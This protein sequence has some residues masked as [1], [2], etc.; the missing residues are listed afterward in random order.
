MTPATAVTNP[1]ELPEINDTIGNYLIRRD[2]VQ[3]IRVCKSWYTSFLPFVWSTIAINNKRSY[4]TVEAFSRHSSLIRHISY[5]TDLWRAYKSSYCSN[6]I[7]LSAYH[8]SPTDKSPIIIGQYHQLRRLLIHGA[9]PKTFF[10]PER[11]VNWKPAH[12]LNNLSNLELSMVRIDPEDT[13]AFWGMCTRLE[14]LAIKFIYIEKLPER[15]MTFERL[16]SLHLS[17][18]SSIQIEPQLDWFTQCPNLTSLSWSPSERQ[19]TRKLDLLSAKLEEGALPKLC[20]LQLEWPKLQDQRL[21]RV[22]NGMKKIKSFTS[23]DEGFD[24]LS[25]QALR[26]HFNHLSA[27]ILKPGLRSNSWMVIAFLTH[28]PT[29]EVLSVGQLKSNDIILSEPWVCKDSLKVFS[30]G[31]IISTERDRERD[32]HQRGVFRRL[33]ELKNLEQLKLV[34]VMHLDITL[35]DVRCG[36]G[37]EMLKTLKRLMRFV[38]GDTIHR[39]RYVTTVEIEDWNRARTEI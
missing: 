22:I 16:E 25:F 35:L 3:C 18:R 28:I 24:V 12:H 7:S 13:T 27:L 8:H 11:V 33:S 6:L 29:L 10:I 30:A 37:L 21:S 4:P 17:I 5:D 38:L 26:S 9:L 14:S 15:T 36:K 23:T 2:L 39:T 32:S 31:I 1:L 34:N 19:R 20:S